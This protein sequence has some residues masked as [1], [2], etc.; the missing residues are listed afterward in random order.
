MLRLPAIARAQLQGVGGKHHHI[1]A[2]G[3]NPASVLLLGRF[4]IHSILGLEA[5]P[6]SGQEAGCKRPRGFG[7][8]ERLSRARFVYLSTH[9]NPP[10]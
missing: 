7:R 1:A 6:L 5:A 9:V 3:M 8:M 2:I 10:I 4:G